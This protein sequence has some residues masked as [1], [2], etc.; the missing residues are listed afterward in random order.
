MV[1]LPQPPPP[2]SV[3]VRLL[4]GPGA[5]VPSKKRPML[6]VL[7]SDSIVIED[8]EDSAGAAKAAGSKDAAGKTGQETVMPVKAMPKVPKVPKQLDIGRRRRRGKPPAKSA[9][10]AKEARGSVAKAV[11]AEKQVSKPKIDPKVHKAKSEQPNVSKAKA[12]AKHGV[13]KAVKSS[14]PP[15]KAAGHGNASDGV[16][17]VEEV[18]FDVL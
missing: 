11:A 7:V 6:R 17:K 5:V 13:P 14:A 9:A 10:K 16:A 15:K 2:P 1:Y 8:D 12:V 4:P 18:D 3:P